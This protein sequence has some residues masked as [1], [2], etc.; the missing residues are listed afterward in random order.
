MD[1]RSK[2]A[3]GSVDIGNILVS[4]RA[5]VTAPF[6]IFLEKIIVGPKLAPM[7]AGQNCAPWHLVGSRLAEGHRYRMRKAAIHLAE[8][9]V[10]AF[11]A[12]AAIQPASALPM[13]DGPVG[14]M[15]IE[16]AL[17]AHHPSVFCDD[18]LTG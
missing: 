14:F 9:V 5:A 16:S 1:G 17:E 2:S 4:Q 15:E 10:A 8:A 11:T 13:T 3:G 7:S 12:L 18:R 6:R